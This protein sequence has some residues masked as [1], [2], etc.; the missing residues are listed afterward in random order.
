M[1]VI[2]VLDATSPGVV[3][4]RRQYCAVKRKVY[5]WAEQ[6]LGQKYDEEIAAE[7]GIA[8]ATVRQARWLRGIPRFQPALD[9]RCPECNEIRP[10]EDFVA[11]K[12]GQSR[13]LTCAAR[14]TEATCA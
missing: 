13:H 12:K 8:P 3:V 2:P 11:E 10:P 5:N 4:G 1:R 14:R 9:G 7:M 6:P